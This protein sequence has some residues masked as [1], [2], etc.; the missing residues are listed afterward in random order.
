MKTVLLQLMS[1]TENGE[2]FEKGS[3]KDGE[4]VGLHG[5]AHGG[6]HGGG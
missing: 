6:G 5:P 2:A 4:Q 1:V 3:S